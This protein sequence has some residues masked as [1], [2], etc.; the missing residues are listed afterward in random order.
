MKSAYLS[1]AELLVFTGFT[2]ILS[3]ILAVSGT[4]LHYKRERE[5]YEEARQRY[6]VESMEAMEYCFAGQKNKLY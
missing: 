3:V 6:L 2:L 5:M 1:K 4:L